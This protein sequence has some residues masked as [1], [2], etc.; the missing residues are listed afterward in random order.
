M[1][2]SWRMKLAR[3]LTRPLWEEEAGYRR[4]RR[5][6]QALVFPVMLVAGTIWGTLASAGGG[7]RLG[8][9]AGGALA[10]TLTAHLH[11]HLHPAVHQL[12]E[13][14]GG[15]WGRLA[16]VA[17]DWLVLGGAAY[18]VTDVLGMPTFRAVTSAVVV[19]GSWALLL[20]SFFDDGGSRFIA[21]LFSGGWGPPRASFSSVETHLARGDPEAA[22][23]AARAFIVDH[24][25]DARG[26]ITL[27]RLM[28]DVRRRPDEAVWALREGL[29]RARLSIAEEQRYLADLVHLCEMDGDLDASRPELERF[30]AMRAGSPQAQ[31]ARARLERRHREGGV[32]ASPKVLSSTEANLSRGARFE[33][34]PARAPR[35]T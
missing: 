19:G 22:I 32:R 27:S 9:A 20:A 8:W 12:S 30:A 29:R 26:W 35:R 15:G 1:T 24:P 23:D 6:R 21:G 13:R 10:F 33:T 25:R 18:L 2:Y 34:L 3:I 28:R 14:V 17:W 5:L 7:S 11:L 4:N 16:A 31:G